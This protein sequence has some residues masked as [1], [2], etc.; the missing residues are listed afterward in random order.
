MER[1]VVFSKLFLLPR[2]VSDLLYLRSLRFLRFWP[3]A[4]K[5]I[6]PVDDGVVILGHIASYSTPSAVDHSATSLYYSSVS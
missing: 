6:S 4:L 5:I 1:W 2:G 3:R